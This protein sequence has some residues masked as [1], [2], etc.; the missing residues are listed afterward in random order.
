MSQRPVPRAGEVI[1][2]PVHG[3][4]VLWL[5]IGSDSTVTR[6]EL[7]AQPQASGPPAHTHPRSHE[8]FEVRSGAIRLK[9]GREERVAEAGETVTV[10]PG[11]A[12][13]WYNHT[14]EPAVVIVEWDPGYCTAQFLDQWYELARAGQLNRKGDL[15]LLDAASL[16]DE[17]VL[18]AV[19]APGIPIGLQRVLF[20]GL[21]WLAKHRIQA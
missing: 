2:D 19:A 20:R 10:T 4:T 6:A 17:S 15:S 8:R 18:D 12:H 7:T 16:F 3:E 5:Q 14:D 13:S 1:T 9:S 21:G 11:T